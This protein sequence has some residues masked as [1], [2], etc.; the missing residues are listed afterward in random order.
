VEGLDMVAKTQVGTGLRAG[1]GDERHNLWTLGFQASEINLKRLI[2]VKRKTHECEVGTDL[3]WIVS[4]I[5]SY[6]TDSFKSKNSDNDQRIFK[7]EDHHVNKPVIN[8]DCR[9]SID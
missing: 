7:L 2:S 3:L 9:P 8:K 1:G 4:C 5:V 6:T